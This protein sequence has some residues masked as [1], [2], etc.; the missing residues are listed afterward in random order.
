MIISRFARAALS[1][2]VA[3]ASQWVSAQVEI[4]PV[5]P[6]GSPGPTVA[7]EPAKLDLGEESPG[8][9]STASVAPPAAASAATV[10]ASVPT[11]PPALARKQA[12]Q[13]GAGQAKNSERPN[14]PRLLGAL[15]D[16]SPN[17]T[18]APERVVFERRPVKVY[19]PVA[20]ERLV[21]FPNPVAL[22]VPGGMDGVLWTQVID[23][24]AY[25]RAAQPIEGIR[26]L[27]E[28]L[29]T[30]Q[31]VPLDVYAVAAAVESPRDLEVF[32]KAPSAPR[33]ADASAH[34]RGDES[35]EP[36]SL[37]MVELTRFA[38]QAVYAPRR[39]APADER[40]ASVPV[41]AKA[42]EGLLR[43]VRV[44]ATPIGQWRSGALYVAAVQLVNE[45]RRAVDV[46]LEQA[47]GSWLA[48]T[49]QHRRL[50]PSGSG[51]DTT[52]VYLVCGGPIETCK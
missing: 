2:V 40:V 15:D 12:N 48:A 8:E 23:K 22:Q 20:A 44:T 42:F 47:R 31:V 18:S 1:V 50:L 46:D 4:K 49:A 21:S 7:L 45:E 52:T 25:L 38:A 5:Q 30:G 29:V 9:K 14:K 6:I 13:A 10:R 28:D 51:W 17:G 43:G 41:P 19:L 16:S 11:P 39:L 26:V 24:T 34:S 33:S 27:A 3:G 37:D 35:D 32:Y 36:G